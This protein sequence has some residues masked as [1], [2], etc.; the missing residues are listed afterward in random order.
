[1]PFLLLLGQLLP[2]NGNVAVY[3]FDFELR[4]DLRKKSRAQVKIQRFL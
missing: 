4:P 3:H 1:L 2:N